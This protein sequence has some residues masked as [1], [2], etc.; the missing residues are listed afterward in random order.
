M[1]FSILQMK[2][3]LKNNSFH[4][5]LSPRS[6]CWLGYFWVSYKK[7]DKPDYTWLR[8]TAGDYKWL[9]VTTSDYKWLRVTTNATIT[10]T[11][12][13]NSLRH[14]HVYHFSYDY[15]DSCATILVKIIEKYLQCRNSC[16]QM[17]FQITVF[18]NVANFTGKHTC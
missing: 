13:S 16:S 7:T 14:K 6:N 18:K 4:N 8:M 11:S 12:I 15:I 1:K 2:P 5:E 3:F 17:F 10:T 9:W